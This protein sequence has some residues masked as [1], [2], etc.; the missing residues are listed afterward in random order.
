MSPTTNDRAQQGHLYL[1]N[2]QKV[3]A[4]ESGLLVQVLHFNQDQ[5]WVGHVSTVSAEKLVPQPMKYF[6]G[7]IP[8]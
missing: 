4:L 7:Q 3:L 2:G 1:L 5:P 8:A 6:Q